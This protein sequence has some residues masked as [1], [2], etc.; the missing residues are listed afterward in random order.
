MPDLS[1]H[2]LM[3][4]L[5]TGN[6]IV[7]L[8]LAAFVVSAVGWLTTTGRLLI[9]SICQFVQKQLDKLFDKHVGRTVGLTASREIVYGYSFKH[10]SADATSD[11][12]Y[13]RKLQV[14]IAWYIRTL[15][16]VFDNAITTLTEV[17]SNP[18]VATLEGFEVTC[19]PQLNRTF[20]VAP[21]VL[22]RQSHEDSKRDD[23]NIR[24]I[25]FTLSGPDART[26]DKFID[27]AYRE[28][29]AMRG[30]VVD[31]T[32]YVF[33]PTKFGTHRRFRRYPIDTKT[34]DSMFF[35]GKE[36]LLRTLS[37]FKKRKG[38]FAIEGFPY[39]LGFL[40]HGPP[41][42]GKTTFVK[43]LA[44]YFG[45]HVIMVPL[46]EV[47]DNDALFRLMNDNATL[48]IEDS[49][50]VY[51]LKHQNVIY[52]FD[53]VDASSPV[54]TKR[55]AKQEE[56]PSHWF[57]PPSSPLAKNAKDVEDTSAAKAPLELQHH[58]LFP[59]MQRGPT[60]DC[61]LNILDGLL[62]TE[63]RIV[64]MCTNHPEKLDP[65]LVRPGRMSTHI[66]FG[67]ADV[68][69]AVQMLEHYYPDKLVDEACVALAQFV[70]DKQP[71]PARLEGLCSKYNTVNE[72]IA[73]LPAEA[74]V[75]DFASANETEPRTTYLLP[76]TGN[77]SNSYKSSDNDDDD[78]NDDNDDDN[79]HSECGE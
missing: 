19:M 20:E 31:K 5:R 24:T 57:L 39:K 7:D 58:A 64:V 73:A 69:S 35:K 55:T 38:R 37:N 61:L 13:N 76:S 6:V 59:Q 47:P 62:N 72:L 36:E 48:Q 34:F 9:V 30:K 77:N 18:R 10:Q 45:R 53:D 14:A 25:T 1:S 50:T 63:G 41:G 32:A 49:D 74:L 28:F 78:D 67:P 12:Y 60:L 26:I 65:A 33:F 56:R 3:T 54:V 15:G 46:S 17:G 75:T 2:V 79:Y 40:L 52:F 71:T 21:G 42:T 70:Q 66:F 44:N 23:E 27:K 68:D 4:H 16:I 43:A 8:V 11:A 29:K 22:F 51:H